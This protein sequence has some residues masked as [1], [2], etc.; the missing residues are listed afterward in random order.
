VSAGGLS[1]TAQRELRSV[2]DHNDRLWRLAYAQG[3]HDAR[4]PRRRWTLGR[5]W[6]MVMVVG[7]LGDLGWPYRYWV[8][9]CQSAAVWALVVW[10]WWGRDRVRRW[11]GRPVA[12]RRPILR[13]SAGTGSLVVSR[14]QW[15]DRSKSS[16]RAN[17]TDR[18]WRLASEPPGV[19]I[20]VDEPTS[21]G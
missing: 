3:R 18:I 12:V 1:K 11:L 10:F 4:R 8:A 16:G 13:C 9:A 20:W 14:G 5:L 7:L 19:A 17:H 2:S 6:V 15:S 21:E